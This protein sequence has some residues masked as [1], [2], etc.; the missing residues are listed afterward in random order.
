MSSAFIPIAIKDP[1]LIHS[2]L[3][4]GALCLEVSNPE[5]KRFRQLSLIYHGNLI[6][7]V[8]QALQ[9]DHR[10]ISDSVISGLSEL[11]RHAVSSLQ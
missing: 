10:A 5:N 9:D 8:N 11:M 6:T 1:I 3:R 2:M 4:I 7:A